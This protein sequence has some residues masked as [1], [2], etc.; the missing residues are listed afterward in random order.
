MR[1]SRAAVSIP[2]ILF[3]AILAACG[4]SPAPSTPEVPGE[5]HD[6]EHDHEAAEHGHDHDGHHG[7]HEGGHHEGTG[8]GHRV[9]GPLKDF[10]E[11][12]APVW[13]SEPG[14]KRVEAACSSAAKLKERA[15]TLGTPPAA[16]EKD[17][18]GW[19]KDV[20]AMV[21]D[22]DALVASCAAAGRPDVEPVLA[23][24]HDGFH[25]LMERVD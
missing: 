19:K 21:V 10:H 7:E 24:V 5:S 6:H 8:R 18:A 2:S 11:V 12:I 20:D 15:G 23:R 4:G 25:K 17:A 1:L 3:V 16:A 9:E 14:A 13:H 22:I